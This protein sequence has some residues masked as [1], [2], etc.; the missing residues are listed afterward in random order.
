M[1][2]WRTPA[3]TAMEMPCDPGSSRARTASDARRRR[4]PPRPETPRGRTA[5]DV[6]QQVFAPADEV[7]PGRAVGRRL[8]RY[9]QVLNLR[10]DG[11]G[12]L[13]F[14]AQRPGRGRVVPSFALIGQLA[15]AGGVIEKSTQP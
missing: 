4:R 7:A 2:R 8:E 14:M 3:A 9:A 12:H 13:G 11:V 5:A 6:I 10:L 1:A 15:L